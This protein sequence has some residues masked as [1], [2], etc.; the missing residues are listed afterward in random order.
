MTKFIGCIV[1]LI[2][3]LIGVAVYTCREIRKDYEQ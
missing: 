2:L 3:L 1:I